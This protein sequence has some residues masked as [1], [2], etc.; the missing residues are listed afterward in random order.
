[1]DRAQHQS[2]TLGSPSTALNQH[3]EREVI[4]GILTLRSELAK[5]KPRNSATEHHFHFLSYFP[6]MPLPLE[7][8]FHCSRV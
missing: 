8:F 7:L 1:M 5:T 4:V 3:S 6:L 2:G